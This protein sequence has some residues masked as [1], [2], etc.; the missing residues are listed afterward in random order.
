MIDEKYV[1][2]KIQA[3][4]LAIKPENIADTLI[5]LVK[6]IVRILYFFFLIF[7][8]ILT[9]LDNIS[10]FISGIFD[11]IFWILRQVRG[12]IKRQ[13]IIFKN[14]ITIK[15]YRFIM[16][17][18]DIIIKIL[19]LLKRHIEINAVYL[20]KK[21]SK[22][23]SIDLL[24]K[25]HAVHILYDFLMNLI[26][27]DINKKSNKAYT[28]IIHPKDNKPFISLATYLLVLVNSTQRLIDHSITNETKMLIGFTAYY[29]EPTKNHL[30][31]KT[32]ALTVEIRKSYIIRTNIILSIESV[33]IK[34]MN[35]ILKHGYNSNI[36][37]LKI[38][39]YLYE[40]DS[41]IGIETI[42]DIV[43]NY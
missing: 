33:F 30:E 6:I 41:L 21:I 29:K 17:F 24:E 20:E 34:Y 36:L 28:V 22:D 18:I 40:T 35:L 37:Q 23:D 42:N 38:D 4:K 19:L 2:K 12:E 7:I 14:Y 27:I 10:N 16:S 1:K 39:I 32:E 5:Y 15:S 11:R 3:F 43:K 9:V 8:K 25:S 13:L 31:S 26:S